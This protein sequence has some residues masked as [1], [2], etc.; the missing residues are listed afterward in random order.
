ML[1]F[2]L[3]RGG[4]RGRMNRAQDGLELSRPDLGIGRLL[5]KRLRMTE[6]A[7]VYL[8]RLFAYHSWATRKLINFCRCLNPDQRKL[9]AAGTMGSIER[10]LTHLV[11]SEQFYLR[12]LTDKDPPRWIENLTV[13][14]EELDDRA[15]ENAV[16]WVHYLESDPDADE[17]FTT[18]WRGKAKLV[19]RW[20]T[21]AQA[22]AHGAEHRTQVC[23]VL[24]ANGIEP[25]DL[26]VGAYEDAVF[27]ESR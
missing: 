16:R 17:L 9:T 19:V 14:V 7:S 12:D 3:D 2:K 26:S 24:G 10:T 15:A 11:S 23:T 13:P 8:M 4:Q 6:A 22:I 5:P 20:G 1:G 25:P 27:A 18:T 21:M